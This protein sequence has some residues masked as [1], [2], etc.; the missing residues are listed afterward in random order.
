MAKYTRGRE[1]V[2][3]GLARFVI[4]LPYVVLVRWSILMSDCARDVRA[5]PPAE[6]GAKMPL[7]G[8]KMTTTLDLGFISAATSCLPPFNHSYPES[9][10]VEPQPLR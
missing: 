9:S 2:K 1:Y 7:Y 5:Q 3:V 6:T 4:D 8:G 10:T